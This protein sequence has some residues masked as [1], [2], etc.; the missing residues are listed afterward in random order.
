[1]IQWKSP[2]PFCVERG[3]NGRVEDTDLRALALIFNSVI[4]VEQARREVK[5]KITS[6]TETIN[7]IGRANAGIPACHPIVHGADP[8]GAKILVMATGTCYGHSVSDAQKAKRIAIRR[9][10]PWIR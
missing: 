9:L 3:A 5:P 2:L 1:L 10:T 4:K 7:M 8:T 6:E